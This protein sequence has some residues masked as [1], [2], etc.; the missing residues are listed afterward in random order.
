[1]TGD[2][3][4]VLANLRFSGVARFAAGTADTQAWEAQ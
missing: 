2:L 3:A 1:M 4:P